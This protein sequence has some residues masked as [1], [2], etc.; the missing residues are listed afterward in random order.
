VSQFPAVGPLPA[1]GSG[2]AVTFGCLNNFCKVSPAALDSWAH[3]LAA[4]PGS[5]LLLHAPAGADP[6]AVQEH[7]SAAGVDPGRV[8]FIGQQSWAQYVATYQRIDI[9]LDPFPYNGGVTTADALW[10]GVPVVTLVGQTAVGRAGFS[11]LTNLGLTE[12]VAHTKEEFF[13]IATKLAG[14]LP[15]LSELRQ[16]LR[17]RMRQSPLCDAKGF[18]R[19]I[20]AAYRQMWQSWCAQHSAA[21]AGVG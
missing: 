11:Q 8:Q 14:D 10:M 4:V 7:F 2:G 9:A 16:G 15:R 20:E 19:D 13:A 12:L 1:Q 3:V 21:G 6:R 18:A 5:K 17:A